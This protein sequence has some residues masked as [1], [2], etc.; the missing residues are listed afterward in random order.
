MKYGLPEQS[1]NTLEAIFKKYPGI[2]KVILYG[3]RAM[4][5]Y[6]NG[7]DIDMTFEVDDSFGYSDLA[8]IA[9]DFDDSN[10]PYFV[11][12]SI[13]KKLSNENLKNHIDRVGK[14][15]YIKEVKEN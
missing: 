7:S 3:S 9:G 1:L 13:Y 6:K 4:G 12:C 15:L 11:D 8:H 2:T 10:L 5:N 14:V